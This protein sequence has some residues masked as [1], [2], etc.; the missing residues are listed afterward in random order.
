MKLML[1]HLS[2]IHITSE[3]NSIT[4]KYPYIVDA[5]KNLDYELDMCVV[6]VT[7]D[8]AYSGQE[9]QY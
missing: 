4:Q 9:Y 5:V 1:L 7:G 2:D 3:D 6:M 8:I